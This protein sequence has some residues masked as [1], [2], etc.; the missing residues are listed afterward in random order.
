MTD[1]DVIICRCEEVTRGEIEEA[2]RLGLTTMNE[3]KRLTRAGLGLCQGKTCSRLVADILARETNRPT[4]D[5]KPPTCRPPTRVISI[6][7]LA[8]YP[9]DSD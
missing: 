4:Q 2:I 6:G 5:V 8:N 9:S 3:V 1:K 7:V